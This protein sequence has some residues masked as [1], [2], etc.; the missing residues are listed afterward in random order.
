MAV[1]MDRAKS[2]MEMGRLLADRCDFEKAILNLSE[3]A[4]LFFKG[5]D[6][7]E[8]IDCQRLLLRLY[9]QQDDLDK[10]TE[11]KEKLQDLVLKEGFELNSRTYYTLGI[12]A[13][14]KRQYDIALNYFQKALALAL[15]GENK[16]DMSLAIYGLSQTYFW[17]GRY[18][19]SLKE[20]YNLKVFFEVIDM[21]DL[22]QST[23]LLNG[24]IHLKMNR[25]AEAIDI[26]WSVFESLKSQKNLFMYIYT[27]YALGFGY[28]RAGESNLAKVYLQLAQ[29]SADP[30]NL[31]TLSRNIEKRLRELGVENDEDYDLVVESANN[32]VVEKRKGRVDFRSQFIL[33]DLL[34]LLAKSPGQIYTKEAI[35]KQVWSQKYDPTVHD[36]KIYVTI[37]RLRKLIEPDYDKPKYI[38]RARNG[39][40]MN[41]NVRVLYDA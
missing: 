39:Y 36:N 34:H 16:E 5:K 7:K 32:A 27:L 21:P 1:A 3:S 23:D 10:I 37:K 15:K 28:M 41:K 30:K 9:V 11:T 6:Y 14:F 4:E 19:E 25:H 2:L 35:V 24:F 13:V 22:K 17:L 18:E 33:L 29:K 31:K 8:Y 38:F 20:V 12:S 26:F 40:Y